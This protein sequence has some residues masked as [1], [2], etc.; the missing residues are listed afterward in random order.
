MVVSVVL[1]VCCGVV[2][3][4]LVDVDSQVGPLAQRTPPADFTPDWRFEHRPWVQRVPGGLPQGARFVGP[5]PLPTQV[6]DDST[7]EVGASGED[8]SAVSEWRRPLRFVEVE[9]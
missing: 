5:P 4:L 2:V 7:L 8:A 6:A 3:L 1:F 9:E